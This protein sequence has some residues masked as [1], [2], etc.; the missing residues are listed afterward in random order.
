MQEKGYKKPTKNVDELRSR[1]LPAWDELDQRVTDATVRHGSPAYARLLK[2]KAD[3]L[4]T[5]LASGLDRWL[6]THYTAIWFKE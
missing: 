2:R 3:I 1:I 4:K 6:Q 5:N